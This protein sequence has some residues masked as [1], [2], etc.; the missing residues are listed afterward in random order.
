[1]PKTS[2]YSPNFILLRAIVFHVAHVFYVTAMI[3][4]SLLLCP[5]AFHSNVTY[6]TAIQPIQESYGYCLA[7]LNYLFVDNEIIVSGDKDW[8]ADYKGK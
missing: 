3:S 1:M 7:L 2:V 8:L 4:L 6:R 5:L